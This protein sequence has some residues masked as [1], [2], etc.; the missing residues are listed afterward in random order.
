MNPNQEITQRERGNLRVRTINE[1]PSKTVQHQVADSEIRHIL[2]KYEQTGVLV[3]LR[4]VDLEFRDVSEF[5]DFSDLMRQ[6][7]ESE[8]AFMRLPS[9]VREAFGHDHHQWLDAAHDGLTEAQRA[10][11]EKLGVLEAVQEPAEPAGDPE[12]TPDPAESE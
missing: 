11:L 3:G 1:E 12:S 2:S 5:T 9:K 7:K 6:S 8:A 10:Q 4:D